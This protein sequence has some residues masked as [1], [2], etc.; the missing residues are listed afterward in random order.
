[1]T[2]GANHLC[3]LPADG[4][5]EATGTCLREIPG[6]S[7]AHSTGARAQASHR[8]LLQRPAG[9]GPHLE[10]RLGVAPQALPDPARV[11]PG[12]PRTLCPGPASPQAADKGEVTLPRAPVAAQ[13]D[14]EGQAAGGTVGTAC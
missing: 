13:A 3:V 10:A 11:H 1:M 9:D 2:L 12:A 6:D 7:S 8:G 5:A 14:P 4:V